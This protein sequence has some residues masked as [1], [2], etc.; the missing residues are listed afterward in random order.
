MGPASRIPCVAA[1]SQRKKKTPTAKRTPVRTSGNPAKRPAVE[2]GPVTAADWIG[3]ARLRTLPLAIAPVV[4]G[5]G[6]ARSTG[7]EFHWVIA[8]ACLAVARLLLAPLVGVGVLIGADQ[9]HRHGGQVDSF[10]EA[11]GQ[12]DIG[13]PA[14][15]LGAHL[16]GDVVPVEYLVAGH[17]VPSFWFLFSHPCGFATGVAE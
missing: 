13:A 9:A 8:L 7:P 1:S 16:H 12:G 4:I 14:R 2:A 15:A 3:A 5:T 17:T 11:L 10:L 6:A